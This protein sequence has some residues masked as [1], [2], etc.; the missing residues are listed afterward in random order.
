MDECKPLP[1]ALEQLTH[2]PLA[3]LGAR[4]L[5]LPA[6]STRVIEDVHSTEFEA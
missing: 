2:E 1:V 6:R 4:H 5:T 3:A